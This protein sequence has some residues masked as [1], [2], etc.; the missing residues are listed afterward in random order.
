MHTLFLKGGRNPR[1]TMTEAQ[2]L[3]AFKVEE[4]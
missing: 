4:N 3:T 2:F 1:S